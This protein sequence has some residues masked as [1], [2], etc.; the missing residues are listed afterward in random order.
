MP[1]VYVGSPS[2][3]SLNRSWGGMEPSGRGQSLPRMGKTPCLMSFSPLLEAGEGLNRHGLRSFTTLETEYA[4]H[5]QQY[6]M[7]LCHLSLWV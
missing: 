7:P 5:R 1:G 6:S 3:C 4:P 2:S